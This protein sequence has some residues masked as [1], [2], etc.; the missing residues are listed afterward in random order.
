MPSLDEHQLLGFLVALAVVILLAWLLGEFARRLGQP[1]VVGQLVAGRP[2]SGAF[3]HLL[4]WS[5]AGRRLGSR[6]AG[7]D[8][9]GVRPGRARWGNHHRAV[10]VGV[11][12][13]RC[14]SPA[15][16]TTAGGG[17]RGRALGRVFHRRGRPG[18][19]AGRPGAY[20]SY[21]VVAIITVLFT[22]TA[23]R[24]LEHR[25][26]ASGT[27]QQRLDNEQA[28]ARAYT[29]TIERV[30][31]PA[32]AEL[33]PELAM[34]ALE[35]LALSQNQANRPLDITRLQVTTTG[36]CAN[37]RVADVATSPVLD[38]SGSV[39]LFD[40]KLDRGQEI[41]AGIEEAAARYD[42]TAI[43]AHA[44]PGQPSL[45]G[46]ADAVIHR[47]RSDVLIV[48]AP[49]GRLPWPSVGRI[50]TAQSTWTIFYD[51]SP[52]SVSGS[53]TGFGKATSPGDDILAEITESNDCSAPP[54]WHSSCCDPQSPHPV[55]ISNTV[56]IGEPWTLPS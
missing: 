33:H 13:G 45:G 44:V 9:P 39:Q 41:L 38:W 42:L 28:S 16:F 56:A 25:S 31:I 47:C 26:P 15:R 48:I 11:R 10:W 4:A 36:T 30:L 1:E 7:P 46:L 29:S 22:P 24:M 55:I 54:R 35:N 6:R 18:T 17:A 37:D 40:S 12:R 49:D 19:A 8:T 14:G 43:G 53:A 2:R 52:A 51:G 3:R 32:S 21:T 20:T 27:E 5:A 34:E 50:P 23:M